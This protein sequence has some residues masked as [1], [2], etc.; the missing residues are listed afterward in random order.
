MENSI[1]TGRQ[2]HLKGIICDVAHCIYNENGCYCTAKEI[3]IGPSF[4]AE[5]SDTICGTFKSR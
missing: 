5:R 4:A 3:R 1:F 2:N